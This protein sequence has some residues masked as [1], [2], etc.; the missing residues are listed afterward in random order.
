MKITFAIYDMDSG[1]V[2]ARTTTGDISLID[3]CSIEAKYADNLHHRAEL[4]YLIYNDPV[5]YAE[6]IAEGN[7]EAYLKS[8]TDHHSLEF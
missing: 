7:P 8:A 3:C 2:I 5:A 6:L 1:Y 4:D